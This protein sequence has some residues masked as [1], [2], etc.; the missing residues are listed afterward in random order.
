MS[1]WHYTQSGPT[2]DETIGPVNDKELIRLACNG[3]LAADTPVTHP[4]HTKGQWITLD[5]IPSAKQSLDRGIAHR[6]Q[7]KIEEKQA[8]KQRKAEEREAQKQRKEAAKALVEDR[9]KAATQQATDRRANLP[10]RSYPA[11]RILSTIFVWF[12]VV[13]ALSLAMCWGCW[14]I[15]GIMGIGASDDGAG[16]W[17]LGGFLSLIPTIAL[18]GLVLTH[19]LLAWVISE[20]LT[21]VANV[22]CDIQASRTSLDQLTAK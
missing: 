14:L 7:Q 1:G 5:Q 10:G 15:A 13:D 22:A 20:L 3:E 16:V 9:Q 18:T 21:L 12:A 8:Q 11:I 19:A 17:A 6:K 2:E 4:R